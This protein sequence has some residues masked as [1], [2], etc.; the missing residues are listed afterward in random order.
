MEL[1]PGLEYVEW[2]G[3]GPHENYWDRKRSAAVGRYNRSVTDMFEPYVRPQDMAN[4]D[5]VRWLTVA[6]RDGE[7][8][9]IVAADEPFDFSA[10]H[11]KPIDLLEAE[12]PYELRSRAGTVLS[13]DAGQQGLGGASCGP[14]PMERYI[15]RA[16]PRTMFFSMRPYSRRL[17]DAAE[18]A[19]TVLP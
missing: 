4:R 6:D 12:H 11:Y 16:I 8:L 5:D 14:P 19:R 2:Y 10:L 3:R 13:I 9:M 7:G 18:Y 17:G 1:N 15:F